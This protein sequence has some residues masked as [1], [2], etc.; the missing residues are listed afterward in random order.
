MQ[1]DAAV[2]AQVREHVVA[3]VDATREE[4]VGHE[5]FELVGDNALERAPAHLRVIAVPGELLQ[6]WGEM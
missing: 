5:V 4:L 6:E 3:G 1:L 2:L